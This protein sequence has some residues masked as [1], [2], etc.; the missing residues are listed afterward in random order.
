MCGTAQSQKGSTVCQFCDYEEKPLDKISEQDF[1][2]LMSPYEYER[3]D[4]G[5]RIKSVKNLRSI[6]GA[7]AIPH[8]VTEIAADA[9]ACCK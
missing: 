6:R 3:T 2:D 9:F 4:G 7:I 1:C 8:F 5:I